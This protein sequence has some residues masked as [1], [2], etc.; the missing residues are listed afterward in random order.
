M[1]QQVYDVVG[2]LLGCGNTNVESVASLLL[3]I[4]SDLTDGKITKEEYELLMVDVLNLK[5][6]IIASNNTL[7]DAKIHQAVMILM[8][9]AKYAKF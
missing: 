7:V 3:S 8:E 1:K 9:L 4:E 2:D 6:I 5:K